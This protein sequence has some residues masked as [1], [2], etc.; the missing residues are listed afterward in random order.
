MCVAVCIKGF[1]GIERT[2]CAQPFYVHQS[3]SVE[4]ID[5]TAHAVVSVCFN[6]IIIKIIVIIIII[7][8]II[9]SNK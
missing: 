9:I 7:I 1:W 8:I 3:P 6:I 4:L 5:K 2:S